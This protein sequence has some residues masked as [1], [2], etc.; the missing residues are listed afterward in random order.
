M[1]IL[2]C[3]TRPAFHS[4]LIKSNVM[5]RDVSLI[6]LLWF[7]YLSL[8]MR[9]RPINVG[10]RQGVIDSRT[11]QVRSRFC[12][13][14]YFRTADERS[15]TMRPVTQDYLRPEM[16]IYDSRTPAPVAVLSASFWPTRTFAAPSTPRHAQLQHQP[17]NLSP[18]TFNCIPLLSSDQSN[19]ALIRASSTFIG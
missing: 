2:N 10:G 6:P 18:A 11:L 16:E 7:I 8:I 4:N 1:A 9:R 15:P 19:E 13:A 3:P 14:R 17:T 12:D 5:Q